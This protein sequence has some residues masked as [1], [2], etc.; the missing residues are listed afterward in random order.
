MRSTSAVKSTA[1]MAGYALFRPQVEATGHFRDAKHGETFALLELAEGVATHL[2][3][4]DAFLELVS[5]EPKIVLNASARAF[6]NFSDL[7]GEQHP[8]ISII[9]GH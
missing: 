3:E 5:G 1:A 8:L 7:R 6:V 2:E 9:D 4:M